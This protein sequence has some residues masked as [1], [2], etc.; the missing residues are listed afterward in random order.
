MAQVKASD[1]VYRDQGEIREEAFLDFVRKYQNQYGYPPTV[2][3]IGAGINLSSTS[4]VNWHK[5][6]LAEKGKIRFTPR[7]ARSIV[8]I[9][10]D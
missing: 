4:T 9:A 5:A 3:E 8:I 1:W 7:S 2:R 6:R 10:N